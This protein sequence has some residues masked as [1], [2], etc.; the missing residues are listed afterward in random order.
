M[1]VNYAPEL[2]ATSRCTGCAACMASCGNGAILMRSDD[3]GFLHPCVNLSKC[4]G[5][6][7]CSSTCPELNE[8]IS[9]CSP[10][11]VY[12]CWD[13]DF[14]RRMQATSG[15]VFMR[16]AEFVLNQG[17]SVCGAIFD[18]GLAVHHVVTREHAV[19]EKMRGSKYVQSNVGL[20]LEKC[21]E[22]LRADEFV[23]FTGTPCQVAAMRQIAARIRTG[24]LLSVDVLCHGAPSPLFWESYLEYRESE[25]GSKAMH[26]WFRK[27]TPSWTVFSL[28][29]DF[30]TEHRLHAWCTT[31]DLFLRAFLGDYI[32]RSCCH[33]CRY[34]GPERVGDIT[35]ADFWGYISETRADRNDEKGI[36]LVM[37]NTAEGEGAF[38]KIAANL[39]IVHKTLEEAQRG[40]VPLRKAIPCN[41]RREEFWKAF[42][43]G[44]IEAV[45]DDYLAPVKRSLKHRANLFLNDHAYLIPSRVR[46][47]ILGARDGMKAR[48][49]KA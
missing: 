29:L 30:K 18:E 37:L 1:S 19:V 34:V 24:R 39:K 49:K 48:I 22:L 13:T 17:G 45:R 28:E 5:C 16:L 14:E 7:K 44:G 10:A 33:S 41:L 36:S 32:S 42:Y 2:A 38:S 35:L 46:S 11:S 12:A 26:A 8:A 4:T 9:P 21:A 31:E 20:A 3:K 40:N 6:G 15:G 47:R 25:N 43:A 23:L 27:K